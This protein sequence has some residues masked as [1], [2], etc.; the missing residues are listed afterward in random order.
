MYL[1]IKFMI[2]LMGLS[3]TLVLDRPTKLQQRCFLE[4]GD[5]SNTTRQIQSRLI[6]FTLN[7]QKS[8]PFFEKKRSYPFRQKLMENEKTYN[9]VHSI[10][11]TRVLV[12]RSTLIAQGA[13]SPTRFSPLPTGDWLTAPRRDHAHHR[14]AL[15]TTPPSPHCTAPELPRANGKS[16]AVIPPPSSS[17]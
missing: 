1:V 2:P 9:F 10:C 7:F 15:A 16:T 8:Y 14:A 17:P 13:S 5:L 4:F 6:H 3:Q 11:S 12:S